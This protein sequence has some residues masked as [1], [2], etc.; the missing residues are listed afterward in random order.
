MQVKF[1]PTGT[2]VEGGLLEV[3]FD[4]YPDIGSPLYTKHYVEH[5]NA[6]GESL[7]WGLNPCLCHFI[8]VPEVFDLDALRN[9][10]YGVFEKDTLATVESILVLPDNIRQISS[11]MG[12]RGKFGSP[13][14]TKDIQDLIGSVNTKFAD[15]V[16]T[17]EGGGT[18]Y[19]VESHT[20]DVGSAA[21]DRAS[22]ATLY[23]SAV[24]YR[25][26]ID[27]NNAANATGNIDTVKAWFNT[28]TA[29][30]SCKVGTFADGGSGVF[31]CNDGESIGEVVAGSEQTYTGLTI[32]INTGEFI[33]ADARAAVSL[34]LDTVGFG[35]AGVYW[36]AGQL[37][38]PADSDTFAL[39]AGDILSLNGTG[40]EAGAAAGGA[41]YIK[42]NPL[43]F[44]IFRP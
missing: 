20:I 33:G 10:V 26:Q 21:E 23:Q 1:N 31:T 40:T 8:T 22:Q 36:V 32:A 17:L 42:W 6:K 4:L 41:R 14:L 38:D 9:Y 2:Q 16:L 3:R 24:G 15:L 25:T 39:L 30:N 27:Y 29:G 28:A 5:F 18:A 44:N 7:G 12:R 43:G 34:I 35:G 19:T 13:I 11:L 37:C